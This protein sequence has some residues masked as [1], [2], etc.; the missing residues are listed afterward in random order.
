MRI[1]D[2]QASRDLTDWE[3]QHFGFLLS[4]FQG[5]R[6]QQELPPGREAAEQFW[7]EVVR[8]KPRKKWQEEGWA[9]GMAWYLRWLELCRK[10]GRTV[11]SV[12]ERMHGAVMR[13]GA[14]RGLA[15]STRREYAAWAGRFG[16]WV[17]SAREAMDQD[18]AAEWLASLV[19]EKKVGFETQKKALNAVVFFLRE[20]CGQEEVELNVQLRKTP[21]REKVVMSG[22]E[23]LALLDQLEGDYRLAA[24]LQYGA[25]LR[26]KEL[27][28]LRV[29]DIDMERNQVIVRGGKGD[30]DRVTILPERCRVAL[31]QRMPRLRR[32]YEKDREEGL[33]GVKIGGALGRKFSR[34]GERWEW[35]WI[36]P[37]AKLSRD[38]DEGVMRRHYLHP[39]A[40]GAAVTRAAAKAMI[41]KRTTSHTLRHSFATHL[42]EA[43]KDPRTMQ[44]LLGHADLK[45]T[46]RY[47]HVATGVNGCGVQSPLDR[48]LPVQAGMH[49]V[50]PPAVER[51]RAA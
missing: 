30:K 43:G 19:A 10:E 47:L 15:R 29:K 32:L 39:K 27:M 17:D 51:S 1:E 35:F 28:S 33:A 37:S 34:A 25:G 26:L 7:R 38:P 8:A 3:K 42:L 24:E 20:V 21:K 9:D 14:R 44:E 18:K 12:A 22:G 5:W 23:V 41:P 48:A 50:G 49:A 40:Y 13:M 11:G 2:L 4:W 36:F 16:E 45:T 6:L 46:E 31:Q